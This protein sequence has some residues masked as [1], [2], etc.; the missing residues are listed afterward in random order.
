MRHGWCRVAGVGCGHVVMGAILLAGVL[1]AADLSE[2]ERTLRSWAFIPLG[3]EFAVALGAMS[4]EIAVGLWWFLG[5]ARRGALLV[6][7]GWVVSLTVFYGVHA[8]FAKAPDC[9]CFG[10]LDRY[11]DMMD[12]AW[13]LMV[14][15]GVMIAMLGAAIGL[16]GIGYDNRLRSIDPPAQ[17]ADVQAPSVLRGFTL[18]EMI[19]V[20]LIVGVLVS[21]ILPSLRGIRERSKEGV[22]LANLRS[23]AG[24]FGAYAND[25]SDA[26]PYFTDPR[27]TKTVI[28]CEIKDRSI[29]IGYFSA[30]YWW[31]FA[32]ADQYYDG[33]FD[34]PTF[35]PPNYV[36]EL[37]G[38]VGSRAHGPTPYLY[39]CSFIAD[40][41]FWNPRTRTGPGQFRHTTHARVL[42]PSKKVV[43][44]ASHPLF[45]QF[46]KVAWKDPRLSAPVS[47]AD[48]S[49]SD[50][51]LDRITAGCPS[52]DGQY[53]PPGPH[54]T[55][56]PYAMHTL[57][58]VRG[59]DVP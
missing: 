9:A 33:A 51:R 14:R 34:H 56:F 11:L 35:Y 54:H 32:L 3:L 40:P 25:W 37:H 53:T 1:K 2:V 29:A 47:W 22:S 55:E 6:A 15:N 7:I 59:R 20:V 50:L 18:I 46:G 24:I 21:L 12:S 58:G 39:G 48:G 4:V 13:S 19:L 44:L 49:A 16:G 10:V 23:H 45:Q 28:R 5:Q 30:M 36:N 57:D 31:N 8:A 41:L 26:F 38:A 43:L 17:R 42:F 27:A 52:G